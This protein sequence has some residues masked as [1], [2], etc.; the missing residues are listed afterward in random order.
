MS[1]PNMRFVTVKSVQQQDIQALHR[2]RAEC[3][4]HRT[5]KG[6]QIRGLVTEYGLVPPLRTGALRAAIPCWLEDADNGLSPRFRT[7]LHGLW[8]DLL[9]LDR[10]VAALDADIAVIAKTDPVAKRLQQLRVVGPL[11]ATALVASIGSG[12]QYAKGRQMAS[13]L[14]LTPKQHSSVGKERLQGISKRGD[15]YLRTLLIHGAR[16]VVV[17]AKDKE[18]RLSCW[19]NDLAKR[20]HRNVVAVSGPHDFLINNT[21]ANI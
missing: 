2:V 9:R 11:T 5:T 13:A 15:V 12:A 6:N 3:M 14:G 1:R 20:R 10:R 4:T 7:L 21:V 19:V 17:N 18:D 16:T 8:E